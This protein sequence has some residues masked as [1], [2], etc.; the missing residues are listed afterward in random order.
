MNRAA[1]GLLIAGTRKLKNASSRLRIVVTG[2]AVTYPLG[3]VFWDYLQYVLGFVRLGHEVLYLEDAGRW[4]YDPIGATFVES[5]AANAAYFAREIPRLEPQ[6]ADRWFFRDALGQTWGWSSQQVTEFC[7][8]A[9]LFVHVSASCV[10]RD[11]YR[12]AARTVFIDSDPMYTQADFPGY[13][14]GAEQDPRVRARIEMILAHDVFFSFAENVNAAECRVPRSLCEWI[15]TRQPIVSECFAGK[16]VEV[17]LA[18]RR[19]VLTT[20]M[21][22][23]PAETGPVIEG[24]AYGGKS[25]EFLRFIEMPAHTA[26]P[27]EIAFSGK[28]PRERFQAAG[29][30]LV[31][32][33]PVSRDPWL[34]R[35]YLANSFG[36]WSVAKN[37]YVESRSGWF[38]CRS[39]CY[40][41][42]GVPV[43]VQD[44]G[45]GCALPSGEGI[46]AFST[47]DEA[48]AAIEA[49][50]RD[51]QRQARAAR[52]IVREYFDSAVVLNR[53]IEQASS[54]QPRRSG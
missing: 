20:V 16:G 44:T 1:I 25:S 34:Y 22:W 10:M 41:A 28:V 27:L 15:P 12:T 53:L 7:R 49:L 13:A 35:G 29:W 24:I 19:R 46:L 2:L 52:E 8:S 36:E 45:F 40:L 48:L 3:G 14:A 47:I 21:S 30:K 33:Y 42:L 6:L 17:P 18:A 37:A 50:A 54:T 31:E 43:V 23:E 51:P 39:A 38:S 5:G 26:I 11:E 4:C 32:A 9:D